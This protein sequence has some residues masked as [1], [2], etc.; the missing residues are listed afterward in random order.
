MTHHWVPQIPAPTLVMI[1][2]IASTTCLGTDYRATS[3]KGKKGKIIWEKLHKADGRGSSAPAKP[4]T[5]LLPESSAWAT[6]V[7][8]WIPCKPEFC[9]MVLSH[10]L[11]TF[12]ITSW[13]LWP[14]SW[15]LEKVESSASYLFLL[16]EGA[17]QLDPG[18]LQILFLFPLLEN[19]ALSRLTS[20]GL[21]RLTPELWNDSC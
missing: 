4:T 15:N 7:P 17:N 3:W 16:V 6:P 8:G 9:R 18:D 14:S 12:Q 1:T 13:F 21:Y 20:A 10:L 2:P 19:K 5:F 11:L